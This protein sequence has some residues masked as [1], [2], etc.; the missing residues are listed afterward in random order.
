MVV[1]DNRVGDLSKVMSKEELKEVLAKVFDE[2][3]SRLGM[4]F[5]D[6]GEGVELESLLEGYGKK[7]PERL[8][9]AACELMYG[10]ISSLAIMLT[11]GILFDEW[12]EDMLKRMAGVLFLLNMIL[13]EWEMGDDIFDV[14]RWLRNVLS[15]AVKVDVSEVGMSSQEIED[16]MKKEVG[17]VVVSE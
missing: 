15:E 17:R 2:V 5:V 4:L 8:R 12:G 10:S 1:F 7:I 11:R 3:M 14:V 6:A 13:I 9:E 16:L